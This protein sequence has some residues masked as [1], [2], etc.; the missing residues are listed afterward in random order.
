MDRQNQADIRDV[1]QQQGGTEP[2]LFLEF[3]SESTATEVP[4]PYYGDDGGFDHVLDLIHEASE[5]LLA[6][7]RT[8]LG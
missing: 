8:R 2:R 3:L 7:I 6:D 4:D 1:W 5:G